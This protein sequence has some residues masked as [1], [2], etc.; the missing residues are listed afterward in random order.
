[1]TEVQLMTLQIPFHS[2]DSMIHKRQHF[3][4]LISDVKL[5]KFDYPFEFVLDGTFLLHFLWL[6]FWSTTKKK[7]CIWWYLLLLM[8]NFY[9]FRQI[10][11]VK[12]SVGHERQLTF[13]SR[14]SC[15]LDSILLNYTFFEVQLVCLSICYSPEHTDNTKEKSLLKLITRKFCED[16]QL[17]GK[18][19]QLIP[20]AVNG[21]VQMSITLKKIRGF[22]VLLRS[23]CSP[24]IH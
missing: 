11:S 6:W 12:W 2:H 18:Q 7:V 22:L 17:S 1:M 19:S 13:L 3:E 4:F 21:Q 5:L 8:I 9:I 14:F 20:D 24:P 15:C 23:V 16:L 10:W